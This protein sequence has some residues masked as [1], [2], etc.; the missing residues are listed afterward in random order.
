MEVKNITKHIFSHFWATNMR[1]W[2]L[3]NF[4]QKLDLLRTS[5]KIR[6]MG[7]FFKNGSTNTIFQKIVVIKFYR[8]LLLTPL[9]KPTQKP[10]SALNKIIQES[11][12]KICLH[13]QSKKSFIIPAKPSF[14]PN[15]LNLY[16]LF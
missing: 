13:C 15:K 2:K 9:R 4:F 1:N 8:F 10:P 3:D 6:T 5:R 7:R 12:S 14:K 16:P 11:P